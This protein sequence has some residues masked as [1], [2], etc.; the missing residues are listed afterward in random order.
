MK[1]YT[2]KLAQMSISTSTNF[3]QFENNNNINKATQKDTYGKNISYSRALNSF[4]KTVLFSK[5]KHKRRFSLICEIIHTFNKNKWLA[6][7][8]KAR[9]A[10]KLECRQGEASSI[11]KVLNNLLGIFGNETLMSLMYLQIPITYWGI[12]TKTT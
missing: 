7:V 8:L 12:L 1:Y 6:R 11:D 3:R 4:S 10:G 9:I 2:K 5:S